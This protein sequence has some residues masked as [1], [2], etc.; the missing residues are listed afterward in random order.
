MITA[1]VLAMMLL[2]EYLTVRTKNNFLKI[3]GKNAWVQVI[4]ATFLGLIP[5]C[6]GGFVAVSLYTHKVIG[7]P[8]LVAVMIASSGDE[9]F[10][11]YSEIPKEALILN[12]VLF[13]VAILVGFVLILIMKNKNFIITKNDGLHS[14]DLPECVS[15]DRKK[16]IQEYKNI[17]FQRALLLFGSLIF[18]IFLFLG[19][20]GPKEWNEE[21]IMLIIIS[22]IVLFV[23]ATV[24][25]HFLV[26]H[27]WKHT[28]KRH[29]L[30]VFLWTFGA[31]LLIEVALPM[32]DFSQETF[33][34]IAE[35]YYFLIL[36]FALL[37]GI[38]PESGPNLV[39]IFL[40]SSGYIPLSILIVNSI[41]QDGHSGLPLL[42][43]SKKSFVYVKAVNLLVGLIFGLVGYFFGF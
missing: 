20:I 25:E 18:L 7:F 12:I 13:G 22:M 29:I 16:I 40:F 9:A 42:A 32:F 31:L 33:A 4:I 39:F 15:F 38:I 6:L 36:L 2:I 3:I 37:V 35:K 23:V 21:R 34:P 11:M 43:E 14:H 30:K 28:I 17:S 41:V 26:E 5:G 24:P 19:E 8:A 10:V 1:F 27:L